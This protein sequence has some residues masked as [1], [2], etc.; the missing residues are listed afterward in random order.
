[1]STHRFAA[2][3]IVGAL[4]A[5]AIAMGAFGVF[6]P[7]GQARLMGFSS[8]GVRTSGDHTIELL[9][10]TSLAAIN[11]GIVYVV[12]A[13]KKWSGFDV[14]AMIARFLMGSGLLA[15]AL[16]GLAPQAFIGAAAWE[17]IGAVLIG[18]SNRWDSFN[19]SAHA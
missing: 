1:M 14:W 13:V 5:L 12:G 3:W 6:N 11:T 4:G 18:V 19:R 2:R 7:E 8:I 17:W 9:V 10:I 16:S 15:L